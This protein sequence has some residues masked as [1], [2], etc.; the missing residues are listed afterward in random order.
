MRIILMTTENSEGTAVA[1]LVLAGLQ[2]ELNDDGV[3][4]PAHPK[5]H[6]RLIEIARYHDTVAVFGSLSGLTRKIL[7]DEGCRVADYVTVLESGL[8]A[9]FVV[10]H[11]CPENV[12]QVFVV[13]MPYYPAY[14][15][16]KDLADQWLAEQAELGVHVVRLE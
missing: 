13:V 3:M 16:L 14:Q 8:L 11:P 5:Y 7:V 1:Y 4:S 2:A 6:E 10:G 15:P 9:N 12:K